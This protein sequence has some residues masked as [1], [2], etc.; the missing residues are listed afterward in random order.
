MNPNGIKKYLYKISG[1]RNSDSIILMGGSA[2]HIFLK[3]LKSS[4]AWEGWRG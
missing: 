3:I 1:L 2:I 4:N